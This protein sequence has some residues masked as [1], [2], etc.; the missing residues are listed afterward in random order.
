VSVCCCLILVRLAVPYY[1]EIELNS[2]RK[3]FLFIYSL[4]CLFIY[5]ISFHF[6]LFKELLLFLFFVPSI[7]FCRI[8]GSHVLHGFLS[9]FFSLPPSLSLFSANHHPFVSVSIHVKFCFSEAFA[10]VIIIRIEDIF[11]CSQGSPFG[12]NETQDSGDKK[13]SGWEEEDFKN[14]DFFGNH[15]IR[16]IQEVRWTRHS[17]A[18]GGKL[19]TRFYEFSFSYDTHQ[20]T[21]VVLVSVF[22]TFHSIRIRISIDQLKAGQLLAIPA[23]IFPPVIHSLYARFSLG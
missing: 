19:Q 15:S 20:A 21:A 5:S 13:P 10:V 3:L 1:Y 14:L 18:K 12:A 9:F 7:Q 6:I 4:L 11:A 22:P 23:E 17:I 8:S 16:I 2:Y